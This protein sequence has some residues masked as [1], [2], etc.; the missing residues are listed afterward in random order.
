MTERLPLAGIG[1][2]VTRPAHQ[3]EP[4][5]ALVREAGGE[6]IRFPTLEI[7]PASDPAPADALLG[8]L[9]RF[10]LA[11]FISP[12]AVTWGLERAARFGGLPTGLGIAAVGAATARCL[13]QAGYPPQAVPEKSFDS[14]A[15]LALP[16]L[17]DIDGKRVLIVRGEGGRPLLGDE[18]H[19]RGARIE[20]A[21]VYRR[22]LPQAD[23]V[24]LLVRW[25]R[26]E[27]KVVTV[28]SLEGLENL[29]AML[30]AA[31]ERH[32]TTTPM[33]I[34]GERMAAGLREAGYTEG[35]RAENA[36]DAG[37][38]E[39]LLSWALNEA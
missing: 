10:D 9:G 8:A 32:L 21:E 24:P 31:G 39:A 5:C 22:A 38:F 6:P 35:A 34:A 30:G 7:A 19:A 12:N 26:G 4:F 1:V 36:S 3:A 23:P 16:L 28:T 14:E 15:L 27:V 18:L 17:R 29:R 37:M 13:S 11:I 20:Y 33:I 25:A 2:L